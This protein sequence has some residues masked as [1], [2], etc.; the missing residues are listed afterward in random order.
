MQAI[1]EL[2]R[3]GKLSDEDMEILRTKLE[4]RNQVTEV[5]MATT[6]FRNT[7]AA[8]FCADPR[9]MVNRYIVT[10]D[11]RPSILVILF[12][13]WKWIR[14]FCYYAKYMVVIKVVINTDQVMAAE[15]AKIKKWRL[16]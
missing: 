1:A 9:Y 4:K 2:R 16:K 5:Q 10:C 15:L 14:Y 12:L 6:A 3:Q 11:M 13:A 7:Q 8:I